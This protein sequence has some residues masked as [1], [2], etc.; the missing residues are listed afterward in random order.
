MDKDIVRK[1]QGF[2]SVL[3]KKPWFSIPGAVILILLMISGIRY[4]HRQGKIK[5]A[6]E[7]AIPQM[8]NG[9]D[10]RDHV[11]AFQLRQQI[12]KYIPDDP[13]FLRLDALT[14]TRFNIITDPAGADVYYKEYS[15]VEEEWILLGTTPLVNLEMPIRT[16]Y[17]W[18]F[19]KQGYEVVYA[20]APT[21]MDTLFRS[22]HETG[23]IPE[24]MVYVEGIYQ[25]TLVNLQSQKKNG[26]YID[27]Y[28]VTN[29]MFKEFM[30]QRGYQNPS[31]NSIES[32]SCMIRQT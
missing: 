9:F 19:E 5:W 2:V 28:E 27:K 24:G 16:L 26:F 25:Q 1:S 17:R 3:R 12:K 18:K 30:D 4:I 21:H 13:E 15:H 10:N 20:A 23:T 32:S 14:T 6:K 29:Q 8:Q 22:L 11:S 31:F 7:Q